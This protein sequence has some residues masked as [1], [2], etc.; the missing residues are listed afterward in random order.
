[1]LVLYDEYL[2]I[3]PRTHIGYELLDSGGGVEHFRY[4]TDGQLLI[5]F[6]FSD[7]IV[8]CAVLISSYPTSVGGI[9]V[10]LNT[11]IYTG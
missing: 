11:N 1:M 2:T 3:I 5:C 10:L 8:V 4:P 9:I 7:I 6:L